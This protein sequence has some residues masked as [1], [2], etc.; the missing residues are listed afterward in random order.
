MGIEKYKEKTWFI[1]LEYICFAWALLSIVWSILQA[2]GIT[3]GIITFVPKDDINPIIQLY[4]GNSIKLKA[5]FLEPVPQGNIIDLK[6]TIT[7][8]NKTIEMSDLEPIVI[9][10][11]E[12]GIY[13]LHAEAKV[14]DA[15]DMKGSTNFY[16]VQTV[17]KKMTANEDIKVK[18]DNTPIP[19]KV[20]EVFKGSGTVA[21]LAVEVENGASYV[22]IQK[23]QELPV[24]NGKVFY[25]TKSSQ[26]AAEAK[27][28]YKTFELKSESNPNVF[29]ENPQ[30]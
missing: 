29:K 26:M 2:F 22:K 24:I 27:S 30:Q 17:A 8:T 10:P 6:W 21:A 23:G 12:G 14:R 11:P 16:V 7:G 9:L 4:P 18:I 25:K 5:D 1:A 13:N 3:K 28:G 19:E 15:E 20:V